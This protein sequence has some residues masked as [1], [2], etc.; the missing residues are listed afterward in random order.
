MITVRRLPLFALLFAILWSPSVLAAGGDDAAGAVPAQVLSEQGRY[1]VEVRQ[2]PE[3]LPEG[4]RIVIDASRS[5]PEGIL[6]ESRV[7]GEASD[8]GESAR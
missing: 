3:P 5:L 7:V 4:A 2:V 1:R 6:I 8:A